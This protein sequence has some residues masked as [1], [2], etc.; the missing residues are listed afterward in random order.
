MIT[1]IFNFI[2]QQPANRQA[3]FD[4]YEPDVLVRF[5]DFLDTD[6]EVYQEFKKL[7]F[8]M[9]R[10]GRKRYS[11]ETIVNVLRWE[12]DLQTHDEEFKI[13]NNFKP[14]MARV[15]LCECPTDFTGFFEFRMP[16]VP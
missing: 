9:K 13:N 10:T 1:N 11:A 8:R 15:L 12:R 4:Q 16:D 3:L 6:P 5:Q 7:A 2:K 14:L